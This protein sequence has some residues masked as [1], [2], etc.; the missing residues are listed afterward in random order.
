MRVSHFAYILVAVTT[1]AATYILLIAEV[2]LPN[3]PPDQLQKIDEFPIVEKSD[4]FSVGKDEARLQEDETLAGDH[5][6]DLIPHKQVLED[7]SADLMPPKQDLEDHS[8]DGIAPKQDLEDHSADLMPPR[9]G[10]D[11]HSVDVIPPKQDLSYLTYYA[12]SEVPPDKKPADIVLASLKDVSEGTPIDEIKRASD[13][14]G[15][16]FNFMKAVAKVESDFDPKQRTGSYIGLFQLSKHE[17]AEYGSGS[18]TD[19]RDNAVAAAYKFM[20][21]AIEFEIS[22]HK[23]PTL[24]DLYLIHQQGVQGAAEHVSHPNQIA[25][26]SMCATDEGRQKGEK[27]CKR[28]IWGNTLPEIKRVW[29]SVDN[30]T[31]GAFV[32]M[33]QDRVHYFFTRYSDASTK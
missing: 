26:Q 12:Y 13:A 9:P 16:D 17:F 29:K 18:I 28:A 15:L 3:S 30:L 23:K 21:E 6:A 32:K 11:D 22:T 31:S 5:S 1:F 7:H 19:P 20:T 27:W 2:Q 4:S 10:P 8:A 33:W 24:S 14:L 25:W